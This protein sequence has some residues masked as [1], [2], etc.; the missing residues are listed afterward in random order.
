MAF[1]VAHDGYRAGNLVTK[2]RRANEEVMLIAQIENADGVEHADRIAAVDGID[3]LWIGQF[4]LS[5]SLGIPGRFDHRFFQEATQQGRRGLPQAR[6]DRGP[7]CHRPGSPR[8]RPGRRL[9][10]ARLLDR[11]LD[12]P[13]RSA[14]LLRDHPECSRPPGQT[15]PL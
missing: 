15:S 11:Y 4:D 1:G 3:A 9:S 8:S 2:M 13:E 14:R 5:T 7:G 6:Q 10:H 12:L